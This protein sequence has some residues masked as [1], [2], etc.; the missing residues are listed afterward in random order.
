[1]AEPFHYGN[2]PLRSINFGDV[3]NKLGNIQ[4]LTY[5]TPCS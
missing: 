3:L 4:L 5:S 2:E 1:V